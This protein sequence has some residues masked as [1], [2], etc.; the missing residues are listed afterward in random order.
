MKVSLAQFFVMQRGVK[1]NAELY[2][3]QYFKTLPKLLKLVEH[4]TN[5][6]LVMKDMYIPFKSCKRGLRT[7]TDLDI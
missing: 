5:L 1:E 7:S 4:S 2:H 6:I 3:L